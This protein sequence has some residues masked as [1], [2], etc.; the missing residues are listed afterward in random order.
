MTTIHHAA[1][2]KDFYSRPLP[3]P[4]RHTVIQSL[5]DCGF[6]HAAILESYH[7]TS[8]D[9]HVLV[10]MIAF[11]DRRRRHLAPHAGCTVVSVPDGFSDEETVSIVSRSGAP[12]HILYHHHDGACSFWASVCEGDSIVPVVLENNIPISKLRQSLHA[13]HG[14]FAAD[15]IAQVK[16]GR[17]CF[18]HPRLHSLHARRLA[19]WAAHGMRDA[20]VD[21]V[22]R[23]T[24]QLR[25]DMS[26]FSDDEIALLA[27]RMLGVTIL[28]DNGA[29]GKAIRRSRSVPPFVQ[30]LSS[31]VTAYPDSLGDMEYWTK[32]AQ[33]IE[34]AAAIL[35]TVSFAGY[36]SDMLSALFAA[37]LNQ[38]QRASWGVIEMSLIAHRM[39]ESLP[40]EFLLP[41]RRIIV[42]PA[43]GWGAFLIAGVERLAGLSDMDGRP[44]RMHV[45]GH[46]RDAAAARLA[47]IGLTLATEEDGWCIVHGDDQQQAYD[48]AQAPGI[49]VGSAFDYRLHDRRDDADDA[50][51]DAL[52]RAQDYLAIAQRVIPHGGY[53]AA[54]VPRAIMDAPSA[55][56]LRKALTKAFDVFECWDIPSDINPDESLAPLALFAR[57]ETRRSPRPHLVMRRALPHADRDHFACGA[58]WTV[59]PM[60]ARTDA[61]VPM[62]VDNVEHPTPPTD[63]PPFCDYWI[64]GVV[65]DVNADT[66]VISLWI[67]GFDEVQI[68]PI[69]PLMPGW[70]LRPKTEFRVRIPY[71]DK[72]ARS[73]IHGAW[74]AVVPQSYT[75]LSEND[76]LET[77]TRLFNGDSSA[78]AP[79][80]APPSRRRL[81]R[82]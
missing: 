26:G 32:Y 51:S 82:S 1:A 60:V 62:S 37:I 4:V 78:Q 76:L 16:Q 71:A 39:L 63:P 53:L 35:R 41:E 81:R 64:S 80:T 8:R 69:D 6:D 52:A 7:F 58:G 72:R 36:S 21:V 12:F 46:E 5:T 19:L 79:L 38:E 9:G 3:D 40:V 23:A 45:I 50:R 56:D 44:I 15:R 59:A 68:I 54:L 48:E 17:S 20:F 14:D 75:Y 43:C 70:M 42:D 67:A 2:R 74:N 13:Y 61:L 25:E 30:A 29:P 28:A 10:A 27:A 49:M 34:R 66:G 47:R 73:L 22:G 24:R 57:R 77:L 18:W 31:A 65:E 11:T 33:R 55:T